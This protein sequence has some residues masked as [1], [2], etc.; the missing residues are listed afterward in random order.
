MSVEER[1]RRAITRV[2]DTV[3]TALRAVWSWLVVFDAEI[4]F[5]EGYL[6]DGDGWT[7]RRLSVVEIVEKMREGQLD[8]DL[9]EYIVWL[10]KSGPVNVN[11][12]KLYDRLL[13]L[14]RPSSPPTATSSA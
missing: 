5:D 7:P 10:R 8:K 13:A 6:L 12:L 2:P 11:T 1:Q 3:P 4:L 9:S 14:I